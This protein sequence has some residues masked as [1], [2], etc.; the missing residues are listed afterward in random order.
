MDSGKQTGMTVFVPLAS[1]DEGKH[2]SEEEE[3]SLWAYHYLVFP[4]EIGNLSHTQPANLA[5][6]ESQRRF[7]FAKYI[8]ESFSALP[9]R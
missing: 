6:L 1:L 7:E 9:S 3:M 8:S 5:F 4:G 2:F